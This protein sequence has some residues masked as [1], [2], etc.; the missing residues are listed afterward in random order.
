MPMAQICNLN[1]YSKQKVE[2][3]PEYHHLLNLTFADALL[4]PL[5]LINATERAKIAPDSPVVVAVYDGLTIPESGAPNWIEDDYGPFY[6][7]CFTF[8]PEGGT[9]FL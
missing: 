9:H 5:A 6:G 4:V 1:L 2:A 8:N 7:R 3:H